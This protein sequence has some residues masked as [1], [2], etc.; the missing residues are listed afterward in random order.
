[1]LLTIVCSHAVDNQSI[2]MYVRSVEE[3][4]GYKKCGIHYFKLVESNSSIEHL[5]S[6][7][8]LNSHIDAATISMMF[9]FFGFVCMFESENVLQLYILL[10]LF[11]LP[12]ASV[13]FIDECQSVDCKGKLSVTTLEH[14]HAHIVENGKNMWHTPTRFQQR[15]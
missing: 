1:M 4:G 10:V 15:H 12:S 9:A 8:L 5:R 2:E 3:G 14:T 7:I 13:S 6:F 11:F